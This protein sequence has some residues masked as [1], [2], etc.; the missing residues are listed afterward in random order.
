MWNIV[1]SQLTFIWYFWTYEYSSRTSLFLRA[2]GRYFSLQL[3]RILE[4]VAID[5]IVVDPI[6]P[7]GSEQYS[8]L[9][10]C[11]RDKI[12]SKTIKRENKNLHESGGF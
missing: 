11:S 1:Y 6:R 4:R 12:W 2:S 5:S 3:Y 8:K 7:I 10:C 9:T